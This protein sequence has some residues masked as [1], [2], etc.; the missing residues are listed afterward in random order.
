MVL[1]R[2]EEKVDDWCYTTGEP[3]GETIPLAQV[4]Q[5]SQA[6]YGDRMNPDF[7]GRTIAQAH[8]IFKGVGLESDFWVG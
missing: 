4:W 5:L 7:R 8:E 6:W 1:L 2:S 3:R